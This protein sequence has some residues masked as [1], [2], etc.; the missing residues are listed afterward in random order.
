MIRQHAIRHGVVCTRTTPAA[1]AQRLRN[2]FLRCFRAL[3]VAGVALL[4]LLPAPAAAQPALAGG[5]M[6][7]AAVAAAPYP[8][9]GCSAH[10]SST[11]VA[12][13]GSV[14]VS[15]N[16][17][18]AGS[19]VT[20]RLD[21]TILT[22]AFA[23]GSGVATTTVTI[24]PATSLG[25]HTISLTGVQPNGLPI[26][27]PVQ[28]TVVSPVRPAHPARPA[29]P[30]PAPLIPVA[31]SAAAMVALA[32]GGSVLLRRRRTHRR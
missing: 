12:A 25:T 21:S 29:R 7:A 16:C 26:Y 20:V 27:E 22:R 24:P 10:V 30:H 28:I 31:E 17:F 32:G 18:R 19:A 9:P 14:T 5:L 11:V 23:N 4:S 15:G 13:G 2:A 3:A 1:I 6:Q 8:P